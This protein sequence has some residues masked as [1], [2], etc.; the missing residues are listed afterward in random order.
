MQTIINLLEKLSKFWFVPVNVYGHAFGI[1][2]WKI[3][4]T[5]VELWWAAS[6]YSPPKHIHEFHDG[7]FMVLYGG[8]RYIWRRFENG[9]ENGY[10][11]D[12]KFKWK[13]FSVRANTL[14]GFSKG[15]TPM[16]WIVIEKWK[17]GS[18]VTSVAEDLKLV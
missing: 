11:L 7:E 5:Q 6:D 12:G 16:I 4:R 14:H 17:E 18:P 10:V 8:K 2:L 9:V 1:T 13:W 3:G 15:E